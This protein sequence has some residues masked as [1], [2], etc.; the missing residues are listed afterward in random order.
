MGVRLH[1]ALPLT[2][3]LKVG[4]VGDWVEGNPQQCF[5]A[6]VRLANS[7]LGVASGAM[8]IEGVSGELCGAVR[9]EIDWGDSRQ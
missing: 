1:H 6:L 3:L 2:S 7:Q 4:N 5:R 8:R 9:R